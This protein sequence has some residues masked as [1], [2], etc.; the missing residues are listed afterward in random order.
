MRDIKQAFWSSWE[1]LH[2]KV[3]KDGGL[4]DFELFGLVTKVKGKTVEIIDLLTEIENHTST[5]KTKEE[6]K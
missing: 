6:E 4:S 3:F 5:P 2:G 1:K